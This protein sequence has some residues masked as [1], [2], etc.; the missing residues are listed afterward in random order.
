MATCASP[1]GWPA[2]ESCTGAVSD[3]PASRA[4]AC[5]VAGAVGSVQTTAYPPPPAAT[6]VLGTEPPPTVSDCAGVQPAADAVAAG[7]SAAA[8]ASAAASRDLSVALR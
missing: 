2:A 8:T 6:C 7:T 4:V 1:A 5:T 3:P